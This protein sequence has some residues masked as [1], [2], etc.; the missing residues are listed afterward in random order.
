MEQSVASNLSSAFPFLSSLGRGQ[1]AALGLAT[2]KPAPA[3]RSRDRAAPP[4][5]WGPHQHRCSL[6]GGDRAIP[7][8]EPGACS[9][10][11]RAGQGG[12]R[13]GLAQPGLQALA[14]TRR[15]EHREAAGHTAPGTALLPWRQGWLSR[16]RKVDRY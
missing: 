2:A 6:N 8:G 3:L 13:V 4:R 7:A 11:P 10:P 16:E 9:P 12:A 15:G 1:A 14:A 5:C